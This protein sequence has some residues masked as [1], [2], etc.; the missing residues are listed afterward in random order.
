[1]S[2]LGG[3]GKTQIAIAYAYLHRQDYHVIL[4]VPADSLELL[5]SSY[6]H[7]AK[8]LKLPQKDEQD[9]EIIV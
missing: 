4:W 2:G 3:I 8:P 1:M 5:V 7:I 9:Q 6:I